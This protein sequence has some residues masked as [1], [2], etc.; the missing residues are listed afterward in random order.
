MM[1][2]GL[3]PAGGGKFMLQLNRMGL[4]L[5]PVAVTENLGQLT[6]KFGQRF[7]I[8]LDESTPPEKVDE[9]VRR[10]VRDRLFE[11]YRSIG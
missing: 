11:L 4:S 3:A 6:V 8:T 5:L 10:L 1:S 9:A 2:V 7:D